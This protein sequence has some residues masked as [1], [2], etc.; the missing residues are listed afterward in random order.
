MTTGR[1]QNILRFTH[2]KPRAS[3]GRQEH[4]KAGFR[5]GSDEADYQCRGSGSDFRALAQPFVQIG[6]EWRDT[7][8]DIR[9]QESSANSLAEAS[10]WNGADR[11]AMHTSNAERPAPGVSRDGPRKDCR[12]GELDGLLD[13]DSLTSIQAPLPWQVGCRDRRIKT[14][15]ELCAGGEFHELRN[16]AFPPAWHALRR[17]LTGAHT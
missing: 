10:T 13:S 12:A 7:D 11:L 14:A 6:A 4:G 3:K 2:G 1:K 15:A 9:C 5:S 16:R 17:N 8:A